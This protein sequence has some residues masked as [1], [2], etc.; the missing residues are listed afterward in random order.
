MQENRSVAWEGTNE[1]DTGKQ[2]D[3]KKNTFSANGQL[4]A[5]M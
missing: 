3:L 1:K 4:M 2:R 5:Q